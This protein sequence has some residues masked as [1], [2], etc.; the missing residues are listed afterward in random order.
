MQVNA[1][2]AEILMSRRV[3]RGNF[4]ALGEIYEEMVAMIGTRRFKQQSVERAMAS[5]WPRSSAPTP[6]AYPGVS[7]NVRIGNP[8]LSA[9]SMSRMALR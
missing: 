3:L 8:N 2:S 9:I 6:G 4:E 5:A 7:T 1:E